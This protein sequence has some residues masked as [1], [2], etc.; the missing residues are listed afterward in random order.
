MNASTPGLSLTQALDYLRIVRRDKWWIYLMT[1]GMTL[2]A[3][4]G[5]ALLP[6]KYKASTTVE[7]DP[8]RVPEQFV[9][10]LVR[11]S[12]LDRLQTISQEVLSE[13]RLQKVIEQWGLYPQLRRTATREAVIEQMRADIVIEVKQS[14]GGL[15]VFSISYQGAIQRWLPW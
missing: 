9:S 15:A 6:N 3:F 14:S 10:E 5:I 1:V 13:T 12:P 7:V 2:A 4:I 8:Q 11:V